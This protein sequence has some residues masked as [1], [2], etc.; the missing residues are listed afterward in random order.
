MAPATP[1][2]PCMPAVLD[3]ITGIDAI[4]GYYPYLWGRVS[5]SPAVSPMPHPKLCVLPYPLTKPLSLDARAMY[6]LIN[7][8]D[9]RLLVDISSSHC[10]NVQCPHEESICCANPSLDRCLLL[11]FLIIYRLFF[12]I[13]TTVAN[14]QEPP[15]LNHAQATCCVCLTEHLV[16]HRRIVQPHL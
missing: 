14:A 16:P 3:N 10:L 11:M 1:T 8:L 7:D 5:S 4:R 13:G 12:L 2:T 6:V 9:I 15:S